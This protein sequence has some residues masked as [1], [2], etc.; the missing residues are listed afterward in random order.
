M[1]IPSTAL[2]EVLKDETDKAKRIAKLNGAVGNSFHIPSVMLVLVLLF[3]LS[4]RAMAMP[5]PPSWTT[6]SET[7]LRGR[8]RDTVFDEYYVN[9]SKFLATN[10]EV[11]EETLRL[12]SCVSLPEDVRKTFIL[13]MAQLDLSGFHAYWIFL[14]E[15]GHTECDAPPDWQAQRFR[16]LASAAAGQQRASGRGG[17]NPRQGQEKGQGNANKAKHPSELK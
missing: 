2:Q 13:D 4:E 9:R 16:G 12:L 5:L 3:Q 6:A 7:R 15:S 17:W 10:L 1:G 14:C 8:I 11:A